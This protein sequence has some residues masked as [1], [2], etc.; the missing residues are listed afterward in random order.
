MDRQER[1]AVISIEMDQIGNFEIRWDWDN[2]YRL[3]MMGALDFG[4][5]Y[6]KDQIRWGSAISEAET[7]RKEEKEYNTEKVQVVSK[8]EA[9]SLY[10]DAYEKI[11][12]R[13]TLIAWT[14]D[15]ATYQVP[16]FIKTL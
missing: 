2:Q 16:E 12:H 13:L 15:R 8:Q 5:D 9:L 11:K 7:C 3:P 10:L 6:L 14:D 1:K 4:K